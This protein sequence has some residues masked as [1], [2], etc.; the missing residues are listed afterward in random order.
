MFNLKSEITPP[1]NI[2]FE[3]SEYGPVYVYENSDYIWLTFSNDQSTNISTQ[4]VMSKAYPAKICTPVKQS[5]FLFLLT[6]IHNARIL[7]MGLGAAGVERTLKH[8]E[9][10]VLSMDSICQLDTVEINASI[11]NLAKRYFNLA[12]NHTIYQQ[13]AESFIKHCTSY[14]DVINID[15][16]NG[17]HHPVFIN[18][19]VFWQNICHC[20]DKSGNVL[21]NLNPKTGSD[22]Q[23][24]L[25]LLRNY[26]TCIALIEFNEYKNIVVILSHLSLK[27]ITVEVIHTS[28]LMQSIA[29]NLHND[30]KEIYH[31]E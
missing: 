18:S 24:L 21:I 9:H 26:F 29:P 30:I 19:H 22:L 4:G 23:S 11:I 1:K 16:F 3:Y 15:I 6:P 28:N 17:E 2:H 7:N 10:N 5:M 20:L 14:Y 25:M 8:L 31:I 12:S 13:C 27:H